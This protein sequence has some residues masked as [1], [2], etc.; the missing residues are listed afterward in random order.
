MEQMMSWLLDQ[1]DVTHVSCRAFNQYQGDMKIE[2]KW[3][4]ELMKFTN[5]KWVNIYVEA[6]TLQEAQ[7]KL[8]KEL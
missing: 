8:V 7:E 6:K 3:K 2:K 5:G 4:I 1:P